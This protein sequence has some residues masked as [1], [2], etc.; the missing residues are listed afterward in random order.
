[1]LNEARALPL[2]GRTLD[3]TDAVVV[4]ISG[5]VPAS[6]LQVRLLGTFQL[7]VAGKGVRVSASAQRLIALLLLRDQEVPRSTA[8]RVLWPDAP[9]DRA[10]ANVR[11]ALYRL[12]RLCPD[13]IETDGTELR[14]AP[15]VISDLRHLRQLASRLLISVDPLSRRELHWA[16]QCDLSD[17]LLPEWDDE[18]LEPERIRLRQTRLHCLERLSVALAEN[19]WYGVAVDTALAAVY[20]DPLRESAHE[21][22]IRAHL[23]EGNRG[24]ALNHYR[25]YRRTIREELGLEPS[26]RLEQLLWPA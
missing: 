14:I 20:A 21:A 23:A 26:D 6:I 4:P 10:L 16:I 18:W 3:D 25:T 22:L 11:G 17:D 9:G 8:A 24:D 2:D 12:N 1:M 15:F 19:G 7:F 13:A 5:R